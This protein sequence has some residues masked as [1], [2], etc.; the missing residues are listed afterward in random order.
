MIA[1]KKKPRTK[2]SSNQQNKTKA[3]KLK[4]PVPSGTEV[5]KINVFFHKNY[6]GANTTDVRKDL[7]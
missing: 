4:K 2:I 1:T 5:N 3:K 6:P 7:A